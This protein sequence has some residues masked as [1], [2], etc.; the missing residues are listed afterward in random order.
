[1]RAQ[2]LIIYL[3]VLVLVAGAYFYSESRHSQKQD[4]EKEAKQVFK[5]N[6]ADIKAL[7]LKNDKGQIDLERIPE[8]EKPSTPP[9]SATPT[10]ISPAGEWR[11]TKPIAAR[12]DELTINSLLTGLADLKRQRH[13]DEVPAETIKEFGLDKPLFTLEFQ[14][15]GQD[16]Q[17]RFGHK[18]PGQQSFYAQKDTDPQILLIRVADKETLDR[19]LTDLRSK[20]IFSLT[21]EKVT[22]IRLIRNDNRLILRKNEPS[23]WALENN[24]AITLRTDRINALLN[25]ISGAKALEFVAEK[26]DDL[27]KY[28]LVPS[29]ALRLTL[30]AGTQEETLLFGSKQ[31]DRSYAQISGTTPIIQ[32]DQALV[33][34]LPV[35]YEALE[36]RRLWSGQD[37]EVQKV[38]WGAP[39]KL[40]TAV[41][42]QN[43]WSILNGDDKPAR[44]EPG[45]KFNLVF[46][47]CKDLEFSKILPA[48]QIKKDKGPVFTLQLSGPE[49]K[50]LFTLEEFSEDKDQ[51]KV[52]F[53]Q[54]DKTLAGLVPAKGLSQLKEILAA[55]GASAAPAKEE[56]AAGK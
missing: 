9:P 42:D 39:D 16:H 15:S 51:I 47:R 33:E 17:L 50:K 53:T 7:T 32:V 4:Q 44:Q 30:L 41:R 52:S 54:G 6:V 13:L 24:P 31:G 29:P 40:R 10:P 46:R 48:A 8:P 3:A 14:A 11:L 19:S 22:E 26:A 12:A 27:K 45:M 2:K 38:V 35:S 36:D 25:E 1:M 37:T 49:D 21:P 23:G 43:G 20:K 5:V 28:G 18:A 55:L 56:P 34:K